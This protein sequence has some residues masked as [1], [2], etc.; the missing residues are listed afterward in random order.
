MKSLTMISILAVV[1]M[2]S[3]CDKTEQT[4]QKT[5]LPATPVFELK[6]VN[7][8]PKSAKVGTNPNK[9]PDGSMGVWIEVV[10]TQGLGDAQ[11]LFGGQPAKGTSVQD[12]NVNAAIST[13]ELIQPGSKDVVVKQI[14]TGKTYPVGTFTVESAN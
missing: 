3:A 9:Q 2:V 6:V 8:G 4:N 5:S 12:K 1:V 13:E 11:V 14:S 7:W 10:G